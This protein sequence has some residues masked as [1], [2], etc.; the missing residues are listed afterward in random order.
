MPSHHTR[1]I[2]L[3]D[4][5]LVRRLSESGMILN[6]EM[7]LTRDARGPNSALLSSILFPRG[8][9]TMVTDSDDQQ[10][11]G[12]FRYRSDDLNAHI[13]YLAPGLDAITDNTP[14]LHI[15]DAM[16]REAGKHGAHALIA[17][18]ESSSSLFETMRKAGYA[19]YARQQIWKHGPLARDHAT[20]QLV[21]ETADDQIAIASLLYHT[22][23]RMLQQVVAPPGDM[24]G[25]VYRQDDRV[26]AYVLVSEGK[27]GIYL[28]PYLHPDVY[29]E[30]A[31]ILEAASLHTQRAHK[32]PIYVSVRSYQGWL[33]DLVAG[34]DFTSLAE[35]A[36]MVK[37]I[38]A[39][40][41]GTVF[42]PLRGDRKL[43]VKHLNP[44]EPACTHEPPRLTHG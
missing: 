23:P 29:G 7:G 39:G 31:A 25:L 42:A 36:I 20:L 18:V 40:V 8:L 22:V 1:S 9:Y 13:V 10:V 15:L 38:A 44:P 30:T 32:V 19:V 34:L 2:K 5:P 43:A 21:E 28:I 24:Q 41:R 6:A 35:Q 3:I 4:I 33:N 12:Q 37:T 16:A 26:L 14:W 11:I 27:Q 17:E